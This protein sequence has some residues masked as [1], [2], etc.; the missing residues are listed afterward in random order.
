MLTWMAVGSVE[1]ISESSLEEGLDNALAAFD[2]C[3]E[4]MRQDFYKEEHL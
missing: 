1:A 4:I 3:L 2:E